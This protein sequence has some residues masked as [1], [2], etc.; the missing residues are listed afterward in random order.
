MD[1]ISHWNGKGGQGWVENQALIDGTYKSVETLLVDAVGDVAATRVLDVG[2]GTG[3]TTVAV[4]RRLGANG[5]CLGLDLSRV[6]VEA[7]RARAEREGVAAT[8]VCADAQTHEFEPGGVD[9][10][11]SRFGV[12][13][14]ADPVAAFANLRAAAAGGAGLR[15]VVW[16]GPSENPFMTEAERAAEA[17]LPGVSHRVADGPGQFGFANRD[18]VRDILAR[19]GWRD[20]DIAPIDVGCSF[21]ASELGSYLNRMGPVGR[22]LQNEDDEIRQRVIQVVLPAF[23]SYI[24]G[25]EVRFEAALWVIGA[26]AGGPA[27]SAAI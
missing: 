18:R 22:A 11:V 4:A 10:I 3:G 20:I 25:D 12:M 8:F 17:L 6:M 14:F 24:H 13:F 5:S 16:R 15:C 19:S 2:C 23:D 21:P 7:A 26:R 1:Q 9:M 27:T